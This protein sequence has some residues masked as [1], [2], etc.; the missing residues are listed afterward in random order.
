MWD[1]DVRSDK[2]VN[3]KKYSQMIREAEHARC[4]P[5][6]TSFVVG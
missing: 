6:E 2:N 1:V 3:Y 5:T 4:A